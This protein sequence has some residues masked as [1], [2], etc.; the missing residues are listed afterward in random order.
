MQGEQM[1]VA[2]RYWA[3]LCSLTA[4]HLP[5]DR[6]LPPVAEDLKASLKKRLTAGKGYFPS[7]SHSIDTGHPKEVLSLPQPGQLP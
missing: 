2:A 7:S 1:L 4:A 6:R 5:E 3:A